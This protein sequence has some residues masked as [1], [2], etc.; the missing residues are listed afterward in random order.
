M[1]AVAIAPT[2]SDQTRIEDAPSP[3]EAVTLAAMKLWRAEREL[4]SG[5][6]FG[7]YRLEELLGE[8]GMG[9]VFRAAR[10]DDGATVALK[11]LKRALIEDPVYARRFV[12]EARSASA[13]RHPNLV[14]ILDAGEL[15]GRQFLAVAYV[16]GRT[17]ENRLR[18]DGPLPLGDVVRLAEEVGAGL[19]ALHEHGLVH[20]DVKTANI[21][22]DDDG[23]VR[24]TDFGLAKGR[25]YTVLTRPG[26][27]MGTLDYLAPEL[28]RGQP[29]TAASDVYAL[30]C[31]LFECVKGKPPF[32][33]RSALQ[34]GMAHLDEQPPDPGAGR[35]GWPAE[36]SAALLQALAKDPEARPSSAGAYAAD[37]RA[38]A[39][40]SA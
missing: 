3:V 40:G 35:D 2:L 6:T 29:A 22:L 13:V 20:R 9:L 21:L 5:D 30:G 24:L 19:D 23:T 26:Q 32:G 1:S 28:I 18:A 27:V 7:P 33:D 15:D 14:P 38:A 17:L 4:A 12:H 39:A 11:V 34:V 31:T 10:A 25:A 37:L 16:R 8:G 36:V